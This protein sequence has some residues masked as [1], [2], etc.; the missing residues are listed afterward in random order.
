[1]IRSRIKPEN[2]ILKAI[3]YRI[4]PNEGREITTGKTYKPRPIFEK[5]RYEKYKEW[6]YKS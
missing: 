5:I 1:M 6:V 2:F 4:S 3:A